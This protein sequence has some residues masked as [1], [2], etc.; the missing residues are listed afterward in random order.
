MLLQTGTRLDIPLL[1]LSA[2]NLES[3]VFVIEVAQVDSLSTP[4]A[5]GPSDSSLL[6]IHSVRSES[7]VSALD[8]LHLD[9]VLSMHGL[10]QLGFGLVTLG[11]SCPGPSVSVLS[12]LNSGSLLPPR[13]LACLGAFALS[14]DMAVIESSAFARELQR[15]SFP[16]LVLGRACLGVSLSATG[17]LHVEF[18]PLSHG[19]A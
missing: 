11:A 2:V 1:P 13:S 12:R 5:F 18:L 9:S 14:L 3:S 6:I 15:L 4:K 16:P 10:L 8:F 7:F 19:L 17:E